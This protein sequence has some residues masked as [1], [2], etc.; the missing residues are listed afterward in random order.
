MDILSLDTFKILLI[1]LYDGFTP[2]FFL[3][4]FYI[5]KHRVPEFKR[6]YLKLSTDETVAEKILK[7]RVVHNKD[8]NISL[9]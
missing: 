6:P 5:H 9:S 4:L 1:L 2:P 3:Q 7:F 8:I